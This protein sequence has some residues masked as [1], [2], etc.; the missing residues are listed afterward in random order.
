MQV[1]SDADPKSEKDGHPKRHPHNPPISAV[2]YKDALMGTEPT[3]CRRAR[4]IAD[5]N[6]PKQRCAIYARNARAPALMIT[7]GLL[8]YLPTPT[9][10]QAGWATSLRR[11]Y[12]TDLAFASDRIARMMSSAPQP[13]TPPPFA[14]NDPAGVHLFVNSG[15]ALTL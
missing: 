13:A 8:L 11:S 1:K 4:I 12:I 5:L 2:D 6:D 7:E 15:S 14:P 10:H 3:R 9:I